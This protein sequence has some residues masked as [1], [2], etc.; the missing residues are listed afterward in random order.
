MDGAAL[1]ERVREDSGT[2]LDRLGSEK[3][4]L[5]ATEA[6]LE[7][8]AVLVTAAAVLA[9]ARETVTGWADDTTGAAGNAL[10]TT[11]QR[12][13]DAY[14]EVAAELGDEQATG[15]GDLEAVDVPFLSLAGEGDIERVAAAT[16]GLPLVLDRLFLQSVSFFVN[17]ADNARADRFRDL[18]GMTEDVL[19]DGQD[20]L[21]GLCDDDRGWSVAAEAAT[22]TISAAYD[23]YVD[24]LEAMG[25]DPKP[26]C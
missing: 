5:A 1:L 23:D 15:A 26:I 22:A 20:A 24:R 9:A 2:E 21:D 17:E 6:R 19:A 18:R 25:F 7:T 4:L 10:R 13:A 16:I 11:A 8:D 3:A 12:L 14:D